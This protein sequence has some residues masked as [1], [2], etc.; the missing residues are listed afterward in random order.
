MN[1][2]RVTTVSIQYYGE[3]AQAKTAIVRNA[4]LTGVFKPLLSSGITVI[5]AAHAAAERGIEVV[6]SHT[7]RARNYPSLISVR[8]RGSQGE[9]WV[10]GALFEQATPRLVL[11]D[12]VTVEALLEGTLIVTCNN[13]R[14]GVIG[15][16]GTILG[17]HGINIAQFALGRDGDRAMGIVTVDETSPIQ[18][19]VLDELRQV[20]AIR[21]VRLVR[22]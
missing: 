15:A 13:D 10:E 6:E 22:I 12:G 8:L 7:T 18:D 11:L 2:Q 21:E 14:P 9:R 20:K 1:D 16:V 3:I 5:N 17:R 4:I 19:D